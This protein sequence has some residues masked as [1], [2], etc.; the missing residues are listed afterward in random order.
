VVRRGFTLI[1]LLVSIAIIAL[2]LSLLVP[3]LRQSREAARATV[4]LSNVRQLALANETYAGD[5]GGRYAP[6]AA[7]FLANRQRWFGSRAS[8]SGV[9]SGVGPLSEYAVFAHGGSNG[10]ASGTSP[11]N[12]ETPRD[13]RACP[14]FA[15]VLQ[16]LTRR[17]IGFERGC[18]GYG[19]NNAYVGVTRAVTPATS[20]VMSLAPAVQSARLITDRVGQRQAWFERPSVV[21][22]F[23]DSAFAVGGSGPQASGGVI[24][25]SFIEPRFWPDNPT[26]R[27]QPS[28]HFRHGVAGDRG[29]SATNRASAV[30][31]DGHAKLVELGRNG[32]DLGLQSPQGSEGVRIGWSLSED[33]NSVFGAAG[34][35]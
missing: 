22:M 13:V 16:D 6:G 5:H 15:V 10:S 20:A 30:H 21:I 23:A 31:L 24:E 34:M 27:P 4:C 2:L 14:T 26:A 25:Y 8:A 32:L 1:E 3:V 17:Q 33:D 19:Y 12:R 29:S 18:G 7:D 11:T 28:M 35:R 9:F